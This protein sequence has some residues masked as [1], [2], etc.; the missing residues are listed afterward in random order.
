MSTSI[1]D[2]VILGVSKRTDFPLRPHATAL[3]VI[4]VQSYCCEGGSKYY[5]EDSLPRMISNIEALLKTFRSLRDNAVTLNVSEAK[6]NG[7][8]VIFTA[9]QALTKDARD[10]SLDYKLSGPYFAGLP[11]VGTSL[12]E[13]F[14]PSIRPD[15]ETGKGDVFIPK[16]ASSVFHS[17]N[18]DYVLRNLNVEQLVVTGQLTEQCVESTVRSAADMGYFVSVV[19]DA[20][21]SHCQ[22]SHDRGLSG[23]SGY[24]RQ[25]T[26]KQI[27]EELN[28][29][30][31]I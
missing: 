18:I 24:C 13:V 28:N 7:C 22:S 6:R 3:L 12:D 9:I 31:I 4:D 30:N 23:M 29:H 27:L 21:A 17:T 15:F 10:V 11:K 19:T 14:L 8:E 1:R 16:T 26:T 5:R 2:H 25:V 20:C